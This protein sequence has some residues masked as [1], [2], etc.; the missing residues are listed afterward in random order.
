MLSQ[1]NLRWTRLACSLLTTLTSTSD[2]IAFLAQDRLLRQIAECLS[3]LDPV[4]KRQ[5]ASQNLAL[6]AFA[7]LRQRYQ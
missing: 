7:E 3:Q 5:R 1:F 6:S 2:G 4:S